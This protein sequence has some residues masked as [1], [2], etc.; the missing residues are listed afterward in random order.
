M[1][2]NPYMGYRDCKAEASC[3]ISNKVRGLG[4][5]GEVHVA[6]HIYMKTVSK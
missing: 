5:G 4:F 3:S 6:R 2:G 1:L